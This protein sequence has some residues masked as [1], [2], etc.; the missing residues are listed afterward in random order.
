LGPITLREAVAESVNTVAVQVSQHAGLNHVVDVARRL[1]MTSEMLEVPSIA[2]GATEATLFEMTTAYAHL[3]SGGMIVYPY[4]ITR[5]ETKSGDIVY[6]RQSSLSGIVLK[7]AV[8]GS[9]NSMLQSVV[10]EGTARAAI[11]GRPVAGKTGTTSDYRDAWF[12]GYTPQLVTGVWVGNDDNTPMKK[13]TGGMLP[14]QIWKQFMQPALQA[15][16]V[17]DIPVSNIPDPMPWQ[18]DLTEGGD[19][20]RGDLP[21]EETA[22][23]GVLEEHVEPEAPVE[24]RDLDAPATRKKDVELSPRFWEKLG[25]APRGE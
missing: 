16:P 9:M 18:N 17:V 22:G 5:I 8:V 24:Q 12:I 15:E 13:V 11:I 19:T 7:P 21:W 14:A 1:G 3:A 4:G 20:P 25:K 6:A 10:N 2:L 23:P